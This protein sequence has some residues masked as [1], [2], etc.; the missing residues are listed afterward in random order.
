VAGLGTD[1]PGALPGCL[2]LSYVA[3][4]SRSTWPGV[5]AHAAAN[6]PTFV[7]LVLGVAG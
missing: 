4:H 3:C 6:L 1:A 5:V 7:I 2:A